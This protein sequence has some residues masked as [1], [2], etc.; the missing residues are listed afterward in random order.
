M[1][2]FLVK[3]LACTKTIQLNC[4]NFFAG[5]ECNFVFAHRLERNKGQ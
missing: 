4:R 5:T 1:K 3:E 2:S